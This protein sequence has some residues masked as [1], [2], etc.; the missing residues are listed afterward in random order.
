MVTEPQTTL[1]VRMTCGVPS[2]GASLRWSWALPT[3][4]STSSIDALAPGGQPQVQTAELHVEFDDH[5]RTGEAGTG[6]VEFDRAHPP[7]QRQPGRHG[8]LALPFQRAHH[9]AQLHPVGGRGD[10]GTRSGQVADQGVQ[11]GVQAGLPHQCRAFLELVDVDQAQRDGVVQAPQR[12]VAVGV[13][14]PHRERL[15]VDPGHG[16]SKIPPSPSR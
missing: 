8:P 16:H 9:A 7:V 6:E 13:G 12:P 2:A 10:D 3:T 4:T 1:P 11:V 14:Y 15:F 5:H